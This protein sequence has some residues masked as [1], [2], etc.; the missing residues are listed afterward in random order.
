MHPKVY[1]S[2]PPQFLTM[3]GVTHSFLNHFP[4]FLDFDSQIR[5]PI[6]TPIFR[7]GCCRRRLSRRRWCLDFIPWVQVSSRRG[8]SEACLPRVGS[9][10]KAVYLAQIW[11]LY[12]WLA[13]SQWMFS[14]VQQQQSELQTAYFFSSTF[15][16]MCISDGQACFY[17]HLPIFVKASRIYFCWGQN[18]LSCSLTGC[19]ILAF[20]LPNIHF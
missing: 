10:C 13:L 8:P 9:G 19:P 4:R 1:T 7:S 15:Q 6:S 17:W 16:D 11:N 18:W 12:D 20:S 3:N 5:P 14:K 2:D